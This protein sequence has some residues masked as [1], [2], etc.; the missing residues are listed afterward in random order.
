MR[1]QWIIVILIIFF[2]LAIPAA[3]ETANYLWGEKSIVAHSNDLLHNYRFHFTLIANNTQEEY[4][5][6]VYS[7]ADATAKSEQVALEYFGN[8]FSNANIKELE[9]YLEVSL[10]SSVDGILIAAP[11]EPSFQTLIT[12]ASSKRI[13]VIVLSNEIEGCDKAS[14]IGINTHD[15]GLK[16]GQALSQAMSGVGEVA[17][18][19]SSDLSEKSYQLYLNGL[20]E[21]IRPFPNLHLKL[22]INSKGESINAEEQTQLLLKSH[23]EIRAIVCTDPNDTLGVAKVVID[24]NRVTSVSII[25]RGLTSEISSYIRRGVIWGILADDPNQLGVQAVSSLASIKEGKPVREFNYMPLLLITS[26]NVAMISERFK[27]EP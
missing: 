9:R 25:G 4:W 21:A 14:F 3:I 17:A 10:L 20:K 7:A 26:S 24:L 19:V 23:P 8:R 13:P 15:L 16:T 1:N 22:V 6:Q 18:L 11:N 5:K 12:E 27:I 2:I